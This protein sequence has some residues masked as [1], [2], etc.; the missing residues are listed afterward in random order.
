MGQV[1]Q[2]LI[3]SIT[4]SLD[5]GY[6]VSVYNI[7]ETFGEKIETSVHV[8]RTIVEK[9]IEYSL[10]YS[11]AE[12][13]T[14]HINFKL[15]RESGEVFGAAKLGVD[16]NCSSNYKKLEKIQTSEPVVAKAIEK[17]DIPEKDNSKKIAS[18][19]TILSFFAKK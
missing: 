18:Q 11:K 12:E 9:S 6:V 16:I 13:E 1:D 3:N 19:K 2:D 10:V 7:S 4:N 14:G 15:S 5:D 17:S 8:L